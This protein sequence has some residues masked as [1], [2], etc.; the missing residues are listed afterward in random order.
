LTFLISG[1]GCHNPLNKK[2]FEPL[3]VEE[4]KKSMDND[5][6]FQNT[7]EMVQH[8]KDSI[9]RSDIEKAK[10]AD[11][12]YKRVFK[13]IQYF[14]DTAIFNPI[15]QQLELQWT[16]NYKSLQSTIDSIS[17]HWKDY[18]DKNSLDQYVKISLTSIHKEYYEYIGGVKNVNLGF[19]LTPLKGTVD[20]LRFGFRIEAKIHEMK[21]SLNP[22]YSSLSFDKSW[23]LST[24]PFSGPVVRY[25]EA[26]YSDEKILENNNIETFLR[27][28]NLFIEIDKIRINGVNYSNDELN[29]PETVENYWNY[30]N[31]E[32]LRDYYVKDMLKELLKMEF[33]PKY[34]FIYKG[35]KDRLIAKDA[36]AFDFLEADNKKDD[37]K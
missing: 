36:L 5:T 13:L 20:Q 26:K 16:A 23:C 37:K 10:F 7:Y 31:D 24:S 32:Y 34:E 21:D 30:K 33:L 9:L 12:T 18:K 15:R 17:N 6:S 28:Y 2:I 3:T 19:E 11:L 14:K 1:Y 27:D 25:W 29:I 4:I 8:I 35:V 22:I